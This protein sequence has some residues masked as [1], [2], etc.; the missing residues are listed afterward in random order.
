MRLRRIY[1]PDNI[2]R[3]GRRARRSGEFVSGPGLSSPS[4]KVRTSFLRK[5]SL[6]MSMSVSSRL[7]LLP[8]T[9]QAYRSIGSHCLSDMTPCSKTPMRASPRTGLANAELSPTLKFFTHSS[10]VSNAATGK[11]TLAERAHHVGRAVRTMSR[12]SS[13]S[14]GCVA[15]GGLA[16]RSELTRACSGTSC[17]R[18]TDM[19]GAFGQRQF[20][21]GALLT[22]EEWVQELQTSGFNSHSPA[23]YVG[24]HA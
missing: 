21:V 12:T 14:Y 7:H 2:G 22:A 5:M 17:G 6:Q 11:L 18:P 10:A 23:L 9:R 1:R 20:P 8:K 24:K 13:G 19:V 15:P 16:T 4:R 3:L